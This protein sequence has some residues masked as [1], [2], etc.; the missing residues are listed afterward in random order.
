M[1]MLEGELIVEGYTMHSGDYCRAESG[2]LHGEIRTESGCRFIAIACVDDEM[3]P[4]S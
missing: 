1:D 2:R 3:L 4:S